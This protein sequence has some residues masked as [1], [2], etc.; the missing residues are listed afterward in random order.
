MR[1]KVKYAE[2]GTG[3]VPVHIRRLEK[4]SAPSKV[5]EAG[6]QKNYDIRKMKISSKTAALQLT[7]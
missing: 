1:F 6:A 4:N 7:C 2:Y 3:D 5:I